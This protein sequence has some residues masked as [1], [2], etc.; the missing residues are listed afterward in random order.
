MHL[1]GLEPRRLDVPGQKR[2][3]IDYGSPIKEI[4]A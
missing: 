3:E 1:L 2:L 4:M